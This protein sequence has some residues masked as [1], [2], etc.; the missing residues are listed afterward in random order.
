VEIRKETDEDSTAH[1]SEIEWSSS[2]VE[3]LNEKIKMVELKLEEATMLINERDS[4]ILELDALS[5]VQ[6]Q[7]TVACNNYPLSL[8]SDVDRLF[9]EKMEAEIQCFILTRASQDW[10]LLTMDQFALNEAQKSLLSDHKSLE[11]KLRHAE[12]RAMMLEEMVDKL[13]SQCKALS[14]T[15]EVLKLQAGASR[16]SLFCSIQFVLLCIAIGTLLVRFLSSSPEIV[17]T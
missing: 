6:P 12:N 3:E 1:Q 13:E 7:N 4:E 14:E 5:H 8:Q 10:K 17:P 16:A 2:P 9:L 11:T 15:S